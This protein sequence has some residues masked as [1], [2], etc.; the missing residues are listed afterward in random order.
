LH[1]RGAASPSPAPT[2]VVAPDARWFEAPGSARVDLSRRRALR[3]LLHALTERRHSAP[4]AA[5]SLDDLVATGW[6][7]ER[8]AAASGARRAYTAIASL[9]DMGLRNVLIRHDDGYL[10]DPKISVERRDRE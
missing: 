10:L 4:G 6:P 3:L 8:I 7:G 5:L 1:A 2:L 9:R